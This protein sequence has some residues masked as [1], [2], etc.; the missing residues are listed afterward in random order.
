VERQRRGR[1]TAR[2]ALTIASN[3]QGPPFIP[4]EPAGETYSPA[5]VYIPQQGEIFDVGNN[6][7]SDVSFMSVGTKPTL[8]LFKHEDRTAVTIPVYDE[9]DHTKDSLIRFDWRFV[10][11]NANDVIPVPVD[12]IG[13]H[14]NFYET[15]T[16][17]GVTNVPGVR[18]GVSQNVYNNIDYHVESN[19]YGPKF[20][21]VVKPGGNPSDIILQFEGQDDIHV[22]VDGGLKIIK[23]QTFYK[24]TQG[25]AYQQDGLNIVTIPWS[26]QY[27]HADGAVQVTLQLGTYD[28]TLP[29][30]LVIKP[31][32]P[33]LGGGGGGGIL[34]TPEW[35]TYM[36]GAS[37]DDFI[38]DLAHDANG[39]VYYTGYSASTSGLPINGGQIS[40]PNLFSQHDAILGRFNSHYE[41]QT[42]GPFLTYYGNDGQDEGYSV[43]YDPVKHRVAMCG[44]ASSAYNTL[45]QFTGNQYHHGGHGFIATFDTLGHRTWGTR[46]KYYFGFQGTF[47]YPTSLDYD[48]HGNLY[49]VGFG[50]ILQADYV[51]SPDPTGYNTIEWNQTTQFSTFYSDGYVAR[52]DTSLALTWFTAL[53]SPE[54]DW[55]NA[56]HVDKARNKLYVGG[57][58]R[59]PNNLNFPDCPTSGYNDFPLC[60]HGGFYENKL[61]GVTN[62]TNG[63]GDGTITEF[64]L[65][66]YHMLW[67]TYI[68]S[69]KDEQ[70]TDVTTDNNGNLYVVGFTNDT[71]Y[72]DTAC[73]WTGN[74][75]HFTRCTNGQYVDHV[76][77]GIVPSHFICRFDTSSNMTWGTLVAGGGKE[78]DIGLSRVRVTCDDN[79]N[80][81][82]FGSTNSGMG[83]GQE[84][85]FPPMQQADLYY[86]AGNNDYPL[87]SSPY[88]DTY[89]ARF[90]PSGQEALATYFGSKGEDYANA[91]IAFGNRVYIGGGTKPV[92]SNI[93]L[94]DPVLPGYLPYY[95]AI[96]GGGYDG[97]LAQIRADLTLGVHPVASASVDQLRIY[98]NP[99]SDELTIIVP[100]AHAGETLRI[101]DALGRTVM[102]RSMTHEERVTVDVSSL[103]GGTYVVWITGANSGTFGRWVKL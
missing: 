85:V 66:N 7:R 86:H 102:E 14:Y 103:A 60:D 61:N 51:T 40:Q 50:A 79:G 36:A 13:S 31:W 72:G 4:R 39:Y 55:M 70:V 58:T 78:F 74:T 42:T 53:G 97:F 11:E 77:H 76:V 93:P 84:P 88:Y 3:A 57:W 1:D 43:A 2:T 94:H 62:F 67:S 59:S 22:D 24:L 46:V 41:M 101:C 9:A 32:Q 26:A 27:V 89:V 69:N 35:C 64:D 37:H 21:I 28:H 54:D 100:G 63:L 10:G 16:P 75:F 47:E 33:E 82:M 68:G 52:F 71:A 96:P 5:W 30:I 25:M 48:A 92:G 17:Y 49:V 81:Y 87:N 15:N 23:G 80:A 12:P 18:R 65:N 29:L 73:H 83:V 20:L 34:T 95:A 8:Y 56:C 38:K 6:Y 99:A 44:M 19:Q 91:I 45:I 90:T 98:P